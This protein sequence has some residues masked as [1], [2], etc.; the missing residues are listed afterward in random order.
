[1]ERSKRINSKI[2]RR[3]RIGRGSENIGNC[4]ETY[5]L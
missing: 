3:G 5:N 4:L 2:V 1:V